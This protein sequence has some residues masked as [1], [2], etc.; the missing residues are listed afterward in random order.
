MQT[1]INSVR[2]LADE[3]RWEEL[4]DLQILD[5]PPE[6]SFDDIVRLASQI[7]EVPFAAISL[8]A[9][10]RQWFKARVGFTEAEMPISHSLC[11]HA[12]QR[13]EA[14]VV[15]PDT[16][17]DPKFRD[18]P[19][20]LSSNVRFYAGA[21]LETRDGVPIGML[22]VADVQPREHLSDLGRQAL[23]TLA[24]QVV[25]QL[26]LRRATNERDYAV[27]HKLARNLQLHWLIQH[28]PLTGPCN[29]SLFRDRLHAA[30]AKG[31]AGLLMI[32][33]EGL[34]KINDVAGDAGGDELLR[35]VS[36][37]LRNLA[38]PGAVVAR[39]G[40]DEFAIILKNV[41]GRA[42]TRAR[43]EWILTTLRK[44]LSLN[45]RRVVP[46]A[47]AGA[48][49][50][51][52]GTPSNAER[53]IREADLALIA[54]KQSARGRVTMFAPTL[55]ARQQSRDEMIE[56]AREA[57]AAGLI[58]PW[59]QPKVNLR[60][61]S[62]EGVEALLRIARPDGTVLF[63]GAIAP[64]LDS[65]ELAGEIGQVMLD[66]VIADM[67]RWLQDGLSF[68]SVSINTVTCELNDPHYATGLADRLQRAGVPPRHLEV[69]VTERV[70]LDNDA[71]QI[72]R[73]LT[74]LRALG[75]QVS[76]DDF[77]TGYASLSHLDGWPVDIIKI[78]RSFGGK[79]ERRPRS[80]LIL[81]SLL[82]LARSLEIKATAEGVETWG[83]ANYLRDRGCDLAQGFL[84]SPALPAT[85]VAEWLTKRRICGV[86]HCASENCDSTGVSLHH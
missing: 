53:L 2:G 25:A 6:A 84:F 4:A 24:G 10:D 72:R 17:N 40:G 69:E 74:S 3:R 30:L 11:L 1:G 71:R 5:T 86:G 15:I 28:D 23:L 7:C 58:V 18:H 38:G 14:L 33:L 50:T 52:E 64:A 60:T 48:S 82:A 8:L 27:S 49:F 78:D 12:I 19:I 67:A 36:G 65:S 26:E 31:R 62:T 37:R 83:Q 32:D 55:L 75:L 61:G 85:K 47:T 29:R 45:G 80:E 46:C 77:G 70:L 9:P 59:Y 57:L 73:T 66:Q 44:E 21:R 54:S 43:G 41:R 81:S 39:L 20:V 16:E 79:I 56:L 34:K 68:G 63:P 13:P 76:L 35:R 42:D 22:C 51:E